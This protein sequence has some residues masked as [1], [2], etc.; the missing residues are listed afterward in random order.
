MALICIRF[1][2]PVFSP[3]QQHQDFKLLIYQLATTALLFITIQHVS[4]IVNGTASPDAD[5]GIG[6]TRAIHHPDAAR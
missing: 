2:N 3:P 4:S 6:E 1:G 5:G